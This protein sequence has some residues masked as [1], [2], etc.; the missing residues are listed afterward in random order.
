MGMW[1]TRSEGPRV[2]RTKSS[3][4]EGPKPGSNG[5]QVEVGTR[6]YIVIL[7][8]MKHRCWYFLRSNCRDAF[9]KFHALPRACKIF[10]GEHFTRG[11][12]KPPP[13]MHD[14]PSRQQGSCQDLLPHIVSLSI[15]KVNKEIQNIDFRVH[16]K[17]HF[18]VAL[19]A[20]YLP[21]LTVLK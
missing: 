3:R 20:I 6:M 7:Y 1:V 18:L 14:L 15:C 13:S 5:R 21:L 12:L 17:S 10:S 16:V 8:Y 4:P 9:C 2:W 19:A 11:L